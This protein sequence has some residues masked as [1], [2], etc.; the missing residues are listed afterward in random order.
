MY[1]GLLQQIKRIP[2]LERVLVSMRRKLRP[3]SAVSTDYVAIDAESVASEAG[4]L[5]RAWQSELIPGKQ[6]SLVDSLLTD[7]RHGKPVVVFD[8]L[9]DA[10]KPLLP[11]GAKTLLEVG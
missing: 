9:I 11:T 10:L 1:S 6:R 7:Y 4:R 2:W 5:S 3:A 8:T